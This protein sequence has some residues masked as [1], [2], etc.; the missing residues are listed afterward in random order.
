MKNTNHR[1]LAIWNRK[2][3]A[4]LLTAGSILFCFTSCESWDNASRTQKS[5][6]LGGAG[7]AAIGAAVADNK[8]AG[9]LIGGAV[10]AGG[11]YLFGKN[12]QRNN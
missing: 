10:G 9:A 12:K 4:S 6:I 5:T 1:P 7:G 3:I 11:G 8:A 2:Q